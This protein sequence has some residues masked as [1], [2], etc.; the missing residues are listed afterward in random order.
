MTAQKVTILGEA[1]YLDRFNQAIA[2]YGHYIRLH[3][4]EALRDELAERAAQTAGLPVLDD[5]LYNI[6][7]LYHSSPAPYRTSLLRYVYLA[8]TAQHQ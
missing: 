8:Y 5:D 3:P 2:F 1:E 7:V 4:Q 6:I